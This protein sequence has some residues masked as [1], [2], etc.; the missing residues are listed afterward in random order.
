MKQTKRKEGKVATVSPFESMFPS[1]TST[2]TNVPAITTTN[3]PTISSVFVNVPTITTS[4]V[5]AITATDVPAIF[6]ETAFLD[7]MTDVQTQQNVN[8]FTPKIPLFYF[9]GLDL[10]SGGFGFGRGKKVKTRYI[11]DFMAYVQNEWTN[12]KPTKELYT[13]QERRLLYRANKGYTP[14]RKVEKRSYTKKRIQ[15]PK[16]KLIKNFNFQIPKNIFG[17]GFNVRTRI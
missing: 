8:V 16:N 14:K 15:L 17:G 9:P 12:V 4:M 1:T 3:I 7:V 5:P 13:G 10:G 2:T 6:K 11:A